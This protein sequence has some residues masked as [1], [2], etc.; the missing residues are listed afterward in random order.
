[1]QATTPPPPKPPRKNRNLPTINTDNKGK[2]SAMKRNKKEERERRMSRANKKKI[3]LINRWHSFSKHETSKESAKYIEKIIRYLVK[4]DEVSD[5]SSR[6]RAA[7]NNALFN[8]LKLMIVGAAVVGL[9]ERWTLTDSLWWSYVTLSTLGFGDMT[10]QDP[11]SMWFTTFFIIYGIGQLSSGISTVAAYLKAKKEEA[12]MALHLEEERQAR[13]ERENHILVTPRGDAIDQMADG[14]GRVMTQSPRDSI[15]Q[16]ANGIKHMGENV[17]RAAKDPGASAKAAK[18]AM[19][20]DL[21][22]CAKFFYAISYF[23]CTLIAAAVFLHLSDDWNIGHGFYFILTVATTIGYGDQSSLY[24]FNGKNV[25]NN[26]I[27]YDQCINSKGTCTVVNTTMCNGNTYS[28]CTCSF[29]DASKIFIMLFSGYTFSQ[30]SGVIDAVPVRACERF[31]TRGKKQAVAPIRALEEEEVEEERNTEN[32]KTICFKML[33]QLF[34]F[35]ITLGLVYGYLILGGILFM[36]LEPAQFTNMLDGVYF[37]LV[38]LTTIGY[39]DF[40]PST[41]SSQVAWGLYMIFGFVLVA[42][43]LGTLSSI[44][45]ACAKKTT[46]IWACLCSPFGI[47][48][49]EEE[50]EIILLFQ[51]VFNTLLFLTAHMVVHS[52]TQCNEKVDD[53][54]GNL[55]LASNCPDTFSKLFYSAVITMSTVGYGATYYPTTN[56]AK[57]WLIVFG[58]FSLSN[59]TVTIEAI[60][61]YN[62]KRTEKIVEALMETEDETTGMNELQWIDRVLRDAEKAA[63]VGKKQ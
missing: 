25:T 29:S 28:Q 48:D 16:M 35:L 44:W 50:V 7:L 60:S 17:L 3:M 5:K 27:T 19:K 51:T 40:S 31:K 39:G 9:I 4:K 36:A 11:V 41:R 57:A 23:I 20:R 13:E 43:F 38:T 10:P 21:Q 33:R 12:N 1:M 59:F 30:L 15:N 14:I 49:D 24:K 54:C 32:R 61:S 26:D 34:S 52:I 62:A 6:Q 22:E 55:A 56:G 37:S 18:R 2:L 8:I 45:K 42:K 53:G 58:M 63:G 47:G 46:K